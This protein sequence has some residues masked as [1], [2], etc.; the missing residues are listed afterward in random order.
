MQRAQNFESQTLAT[1]DAAKCSLMIPAMY[2]AYFKHRCNDLGSRKNYLHY[3]VD[4]FLPL[5]NRF[6]SLLKHSKKEQWNTHYQ[7]EKLELKKRSFVPV[8]E[9]WEC[10]RHASMGFGVS[11][12]FLFV[13]LMELEMD[14][15]LQV[16]EGAGKLGRSSSLDR[17]RS[18]RK[19]VNLSILI[20]RV[21]LKRRRL[22]RQHRT[23]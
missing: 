20:R 21:D 4:H 7:A 22:T 10:L 14:G 13:F 5:S 23:R 11:M 8:P 2:L 3:L 19:F 12:C 16:G 15:E 9:D 17:D 1:S 18:E 6:A